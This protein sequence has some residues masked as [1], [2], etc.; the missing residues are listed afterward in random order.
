M[1]ERIRASPAVQANRPWSLPASIAFIAVFIPALLWLSFGYVDG[2]SLALA[3][4]FILLVLGIHFGAKPRDDANDVRTPD[5]KRHP[6]DF[7]CVVWGLSIPF[8]PFLAWT[9]TSLVPVEA[10]NWRWLLGIRALLCVVIPL[11][12]V[13]QMLRFLRRPHLALML[14]I[15]LVGT[16][17]PVTIG[18]GSAYDFVTG[19]RWQSADV[20]EL[21]DIS[22]N[23]KG[24]KVRI[25]D[26]FVDLADGRTLRRSSE[27]QVTIGPAKLHILRGFGRIIAAEP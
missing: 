1:I 11:V 26:A 5:Y 21:R 20:I 8:G 17:F 13:L 12:C 16:S 3:G 9:L 7:L 6:L 18:A 24:R 19:P 4:F 22:F 23:R 10:S 25:P 15:L 2:V 14:S 27:A